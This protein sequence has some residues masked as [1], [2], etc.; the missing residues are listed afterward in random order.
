MLI[1]KIGNLVRGL[2]LRVDIFDNPEIVFNDTQNRS[3]GIG[4]VQKIEPDKNGQKW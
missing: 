1:S 2:K 3:I 4:Y